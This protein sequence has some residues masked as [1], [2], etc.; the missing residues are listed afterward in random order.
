MME[1]YIEEEHDSINEEEDDVPLSIEDI[2]FGKRS[3]ADYESEFTKRLPS[4]PCTGHEVLSAISGIANAYQVAYNCSAR[5]TV[6]CAK[7]EKDY[8]IKRNE[9]ITAKISQIKTAA[10]KPTKLP[11]RETIES[12]VFDESKELG[13][14]VSDFK[15]WE[16]IK[17]WFDSHVKKLGQMLSSAKDISYAVHNSERMYSK[18]NV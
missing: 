2:Y 11:S 13:I 5:L 14:L 18:G 17:E 1:A 4:I 6:I 3:L 8:K 15:K 10:G 9:M 7:A 16:M 12:M